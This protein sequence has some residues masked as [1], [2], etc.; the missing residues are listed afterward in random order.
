MPR[1]KTVQLAPTK[2]IETDELIIEIRDKDTREIGPGLDKKFN[3]NELDWQILTG[4]VDMYL[5][6][7]RKQRKLA[8]EL[9]EN[10]RMESKFARKLEEWGYELSDRAMR[11]HAKRVR[12]HWRALMAAQS[13]S[14]QTDSKPE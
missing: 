14:E 3:A 7:D 4:L 8:V 2:V 10:K 6:E 1:K 12:E 11:E 9:L 5:S 13:S